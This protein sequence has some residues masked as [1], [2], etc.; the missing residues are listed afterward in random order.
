[1]NWFLKE[2]DFIREYDLGYNIYPMVSKMIGYIPRDTEEQLN[3]FGGEESE[4]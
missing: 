2:Y 1:M 4:I 3:L